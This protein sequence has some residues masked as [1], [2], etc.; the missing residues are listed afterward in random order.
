MTE[1]LIFCYLITVSEK[2]IEYLKHIIQ[3]MIGLNYYNNLKSIKIFR[4]EVNESFMDKKFLL[5]NP[6]YKILENQVN[7]PELGLIFHV[8]KTNSKQKFKFSSLFNKK[9]LQF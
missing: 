9:K 4:Q 7:H 3:S 5:Q 2:N 1:I 8:V 6:D